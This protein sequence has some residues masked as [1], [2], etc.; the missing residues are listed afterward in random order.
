[1]KLL[2]CGTNW[3]VIEIQNSSTS[4]GF[5]DA[6]QIE[7]EAIA[8]VDC[9][10]DRCVFGEPAGFVDSRLKIELAAKDAT[11]K[12]AGD[13][14]GIGGFRTVTKPATGWWHFAKGSDIDD[15]RAVPTV[16]VAAGDRA[17]EFRD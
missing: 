6:G 12:L 9:G 8:H 13:E 1:M 16:G 14:D 7:R 11:T 4:A 3:H 2:S 15:E 5:A 10:V 17:I